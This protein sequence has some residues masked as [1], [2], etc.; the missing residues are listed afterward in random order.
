M[1]D[2]SVSKPIESSTRAQ[3]LRQCRRRD[4]L[5]DRDLDVS[6]PV[7]PFENLDRPSFK[8]ATDGLVRREVDDQ[9]PRTS[10]KKG[11]ARP[12]AAMAF[13]GRASRACRTNVIGAFVRSKSILS[14]REGPPEIPQIANLARHRSFGLDDGMGP[15]RCPPSRLGLFMGLPELLLRPAVLSRREGPWSPRRPWPPRQDGLPGPRRDGSGPTGF[16]GL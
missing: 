1:V 4:R 2:P 13:V 7:R 14:Q 12:P 8:V 15:E 16:S 6:D 3:N 9:I 5:P 11:T 10:P